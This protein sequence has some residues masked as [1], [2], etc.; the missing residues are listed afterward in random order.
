MARLVVRLLG[1]FDVRLDDAPITTFAYDKVRALLAY[2]VTE[3][4]HPVRRER[5][6]GLLWPDY[7]ERSARQNLSQA[8]FTLRNALGDTAG[9][10]DDSHY[11]LAS[12]Q[13]IEFACTD[14]VWSDVNGFDAAVKATRTHTHADLRACES[15]LAQLA[16]AVALYRGDFLEDLSLDDSAAFEEWALLQR[17]RLRQLEL[18]ALDV[19]SDSALQHGDIEAAL[20]YARRQLALDP[21]RE[22]AHR[23]V[24]RAL[25][26]NGQRTAA[27]AQYEACRA[28]LKDEL[29]VAP[30][31]ATT[32]LYTAIRDAEGIDTAVL[33][34]PSGLL[35]APGESPFKGLHFFDVE[36]ADLFFGREALTT[37]LVERLT[38]GERFL[39]IVGASGS[40]KSSL[41]RAGLATLLTH[42]GAGAAPGWT[43]RVI[44]PT[45][46]PV[47][48]LCRGL[49][50]TVEDETTVR[51]LTRAL[52]TDPQTLQRCGQQ[53]M[54]L[55]RMTGEPPNP[56]HPPANA[57]TGTRLLIVV[58]QF[59]EVFTLCHDLSHRQAFIDALLAAASSPGTTHIVIALR[60]DLYHL[61]AQHETL[62]LALES[63]QVFIGAM[64][65]EELQRAIELPAQRGSWT[66]EPGL[67]ELLLRD[68]G[69]DRPEP[70]ALP[71]LS[72]ALLET[73]KR[74][75][76]RT[77][78]LKGY[79]NAGGVRGAIA[80]SA[81]ATYRALTPDEQ[82]I[83]RGIFLRLTEMGD[84]A[85]DVSGT[86]YTRRRA[87]L[88]EVLL[89]SVPEA[90]VQTVLNTLAR[91][92]LITMQRDAVEVAHEALIREWPT[93]RGWLEA[94]LEGL[95]LHR[96]LTE[97]T[98]AW[99]AADRDP[100]DLY[101]GARLAQAEEWARDAE[102]VL[103]PLERE[104]LLASRLEAE[105]LE[106]AREAQ[107]QR[108]LEA[109]Q[110][111]AEAQRRR[112][113]ER[114]RFLRWLALASGLL[115]VAT[116][117]A[118]LLGRGY[119]RAS[120]ASAA[121]ADANAT[122]AAANAAVAATAQAAEAE[123]IAAREQAA[124]ERSAAVY[125]QQLEAAQRARAEA[126]RAV[127]DEQARIAKSNLLAVQS[128]QLL[129]ENYALALLLSTEAYDVRDGPG[130]R[131]AMLSALE[132]YPSVLGYL[133]PPVPA[134]YAVAFSPNSAHLSVVGDSVVY[135]SKRLTLF[136][137]DRANHQQ[138][139]KPQEVPLGGQSVVLNH[140]AYSPDDS[141]LAYGA[142][143]QFVQDG[144]CIRGSITL[145]SPDTNEVISELVGHTYTV[146][147][148]TYDPAGRYLASYGDETV[149]LWDVRDPSQTEVAHELTGHTTDVFATSFSP[150]GRLLASVGFDTDAPNEGAF[151]TL[152]YVRI[153]DVETGTLE[154]QLPY[155]GKGFYSLEFSPDGSVLAT[156]GC[157]KFGVDQHA[158]ERGLVRRWN[159]ADGQEILPAIV[160]GP[161]HVYGLYFVGGGDRL[162]ASMHTAIAVWEIAGDSLQ[163]AE[164][165][166]PLSSAYSAL[167]PDGRI[168][169]RF[170]DDE[171]T[172][173]D[174]EML[175]RQTT[176]RTDRV[177]ASTTPLPLGGMDLSPDGSLIAA[178]CADNK[179]YIWET[180][181]GKLA[182]RPL[183][184]TT[185]WTVAFSPDGRTLASGSDDTTVRL[186]DVATREAIHPPRQGHTSTVTSVGFSPN[187]ALLASA[188][189]DG[190]FRLWDVTTGEVLSV[191][192]AM[193]TPPIS[194]PG[195]WDVDFSPDA[196]IL[197]VGLSIPEGDAVLWDVHDAT[198]PTVIA[199]LPTVNK[200]GATQVAFSPDGNT[201]AVSV[202]VGGIVQLW[203]LRSLESAPPITAHR[204][205]SWPLAF[206]P[207]G[208]ILASGATESTL[209]LIDVE[210][211]TII[212]PQLRLH[213][214]DRAAMPVSLAFSP[215]GR[216][217]YSS[218]TDGTLRAWDVDP[219]SWRVRACD[220]AGRNLT[221]AEWAQYL[222][223]EPYR[224]TCSRWPAGE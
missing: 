146:R 207:D 169:A 91:A 110:R 61:C 145:L 193:T 179:I 130:A 219:E 86:L 3:A 128:G 67:I 152:H 211:A 38:G 174:T 192:R 39:A 31:I 201:V 158:C 144:A 124:T 102:S 162:L 131:G 165:V 178:G 137:Y 52:L 98:Q 8:L 14:G 167:S 218:S 21:W 149:L 121:I 45:A 188:S 46:N 97:A 197:A 95:R 186:W 142:C 27:L 90:D 60:A 26:L 195:V 222:P 111:L 119:R 180:A 216:L 156:G 113:E 57:H 94:D 50:G 120:L 4:G 54:T 217:L 191:N 132:A 214:D 168:L 71:L 153:W 78:T 55:G 150:N 140:L 53:L 200:G 43:V 163:G 59:E 125:A 221:R 147:G 204:W 220:I 143:A 184:G 189:H 56:E 42:G 10:G 47:D 133:Y 116:V 11:L 63:H 12:R 170:T 224:V 64:T 29:Q 58:D 34:P 112:A 44:T 199:R 203:D 209:R 176:T 185:A 108:E 148:V 141:S 19:L 194:E 25:A 122:T 80:Q 24:M 41:V 106:A 37:R 2:L 68:V 79:A 89:A 196:E 104:F 157:S 13:T 161:D 205:T 107:R 100:A 177:L 206:S 172:F 76:G 62:R 9:R 213:K 36:D 223:D 49:L 96:H 6:T 190:T 87:T 99:A 182:G 103:N 136:T 115:L 23:Q 109:A 66:F 129:E 175:Q 135:G 73:W 65:P 20:R 164:I 114:G 30:E 92:R 127:A 198:A 77:L 40:G 15:C 88:Q 105:R 171:I 75:Q 85:E 1:R 166:V 84:A 28:L 212:G 159:L 154:R 117:V 74:R 33:L 101:R 93:L 155:Y 134:I 215:D 139:G 187:G 83:A 48:A 126:A 5:L 16:E 69:T 123:A 81:E 17:E 160:D 32:A 82:Q 208:Q 181:T 173:Y 72:H 7:P 18:E 210:T 138:I 70:G 51:A 183:E 35:P 118:M 151:D 202:G 22:P